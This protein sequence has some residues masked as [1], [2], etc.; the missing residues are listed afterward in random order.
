MSKVIG[1]VR[2]PG[3][4]CEFDTIDALQILGAETKFFGMGIEI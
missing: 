1:V 4:N 2:F 3:T